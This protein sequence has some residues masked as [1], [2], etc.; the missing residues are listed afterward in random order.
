LALLDTLEAELWTAT[1][2]FIEDPAFRKNM[3]R[4]GV[5]DEDIRKNIMASF[6]FPPSQFQLHVQ[7]IVPPMMPFHHH[8]TENK[9]HYVEGRAFPLTYVRKV[10]ALNQPYKVTKDTPI[11][12]IT[13]YYDKLGVDYK[14][15][16]STWFEEICLK[17]DLSFQ[18]WEPD[19]FE[20]VVQ[21][22]KAYGFR[23]VDGKI[24]LGD[25]NADAVPTTLQAKD[26]LLIQNYG[27]A[28]DVAGKPTGTYIGRPVAPKIGGA[29]YSQW[30]GVQWGDSVNIV[31]S[32]FKSLDPDDSG[33]MAESMLRKALMKVGCQAS[34]LD[35]LICKGSEDWKNGDGMI[36]YGVF[37]RWLLG[38]DISK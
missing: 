11:E 9:N 3:Y 10:L 28:D 17:G 18:N 13:A 15:E 32:A 21:D 14:K 30:P 8:M 4:E 25:V 19:C 2:S 6:N 5:T 20:Y 7:W 31:M 24:E 23:T 33:L 36:R 38:S 22:G 26:K 34:D 1:K 29:G 12:D 16:W 27:R 35:V 37:V